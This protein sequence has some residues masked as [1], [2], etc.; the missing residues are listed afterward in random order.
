MESYGDLT[1]VPVDEKRFG[2]H[3]KRATLGIASGNL[4]LAWRMILLQ[5][6]KERSRRLERR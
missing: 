2:T 6:V 3:G 4:R 5:I 1:D